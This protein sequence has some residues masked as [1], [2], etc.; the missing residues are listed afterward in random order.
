[1]KWFLFVILGVLGLNLVVIALV[2]FILLSDWIRGHGKKTEIK[3]F[4]G[5]PKSKNL[6]R[7]GS[8]PPD[9]TRSKAG[10]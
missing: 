10:S 5:S 9:R 4:P 8:L 1:L 2:G 7:P 6:K 3:P